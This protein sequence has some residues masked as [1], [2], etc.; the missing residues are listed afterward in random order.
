MTFTLPD[1]PYAKDAFGKTISAETFEFHHGK[2]HKAYVD[3]TNELVAKDKQLSG[4]RLSDVIAAAQESGNK[5]FVQQ[6][7]ATVEPQFLL[8]V[9]FARTA[10]AFGQAERHDRRRIRQSGRYAC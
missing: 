2:H 3:K 4:A 9:P 10:N 6:R 5:P 8:A 7:G 1:L